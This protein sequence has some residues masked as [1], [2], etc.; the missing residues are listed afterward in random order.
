MNKK[1]ISNSNYVLRKVLNNQESIPIIKDLIETILDVNI[2]QININPYLKKREKFLPSENRFGIVDVRIKTRGKEEMNIGIQFIDGI[3]YIKTKMLLYYSQI[4]FNQIEY[5]DNRNIAKTV[6]INFIENSLFSIPK[7]KEIINIKT[8]KS[9]SRLLEGIEMYIIELSK[10]KIKQIDKSNKEEDWIAY[11]KGD[12]RENIEK[13]AK[14]NRN[15][16]LLDKK[17]NEYWNNEKME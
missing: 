13:I 15:I 3:Y 11:I 16:Y 4:H 10:F 2:E 12:T 14:K 9:N 5:N 6:T 1:L 17:I 8:K 7:Y